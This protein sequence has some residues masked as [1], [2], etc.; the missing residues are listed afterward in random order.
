MAIE[1]LKLNLHSPLE[2]PPLYDRAYEF[3]VSSWDVHI[4]DHPEW[5]SLKATIINYIQRAIYAKEQLK[6][7][8]PKA[9]SNIYAMNVIICEIVGYN[10]KVLPSEYVTYVKLHITPSEYASGIF[11]SKL[12]DYNKTL[13]TKLEYEILCTY[14]N[15]NYKN[16][17]GFE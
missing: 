15:N 16:H 9:A 6:L 13:K 8:F 7:T 17:I 11:S 4:V 10:N 2:E 5:K 14:T 12:D 1:N 3:D